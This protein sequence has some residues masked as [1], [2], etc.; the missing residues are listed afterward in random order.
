MKPEW[1]PDWTGQTCVIVASGPSARTVP[2]ELARGKAKFIVINHSWQLAPWADVL[3]AAD[4][5]WWRESKGC[6]DFKGLKVAGEIRASRE[7]WGVN[8]VTIAKGDSRLLLNE[9]GRIGYGHS[10]GFQALNLAVQFGV[11]K[12][13]LV[14]YD[15]RLD[16]GVHWHGKHGPRMNNPTEKLAGIWRSAL[17]RVSDE[18]KRL[19]VTVINVS[20]VSKL[21][22]YPKMK[23]EDAI[24]A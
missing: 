17:D 8:F 20:E 24:N 10:S 5:G 2:L 13:V 6:P 11:K 23:F 14:G 9:P 22:S 12:I 15:M 18:F 19:G 7:G 21:E 1:Y 3:Y 4:Y 16:N